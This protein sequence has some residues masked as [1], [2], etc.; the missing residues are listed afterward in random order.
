MTA[1][2]LNPFAVTV[3]LILLVAA[4]WTDVEER[5][6]PN[7]LVLHGMLI[8]LVMAVL[9][10]GS[11]GLVMALAGIVIG[12]L[13]LLPFYAVGGMG[14]GDVK[15]V[16]MVGAFVGPDLAAAAVAMTLVAGVVEAGAYLLAWRLGEWRAAHPRGGTTRAHDTHEPPKD[17]PYALAILAGTVGALIWA[18]QK[19]LPVAG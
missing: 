7:A 10:A 13:M 15:L 3:L 19:S 1:L 14:A 18:L 11:E 2:P 9:A 16:A 6:I 4:A 17:F 8:A 5:R 12:G